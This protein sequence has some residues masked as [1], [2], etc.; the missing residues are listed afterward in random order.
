M[1]N[2]TI[3]WYELMRKNKSKLYDLSIS[4]IS[5]FIKKI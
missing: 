2:L 3:S 5:F 4:Q 1:I